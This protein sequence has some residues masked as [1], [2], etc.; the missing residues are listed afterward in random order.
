MHRLTRVDS[1][2]PDESAE[3]QQAE[4]IKLQRQFR[5][6]EDDRRAY[7]EEAEHI[8]KKQ[9]DTIA[10]LTLEHEELEKDNKLAGSQRNQT[11]DAGNTSKLHSLL[12]EEELTAKDTV[13]E[14]ERLR[15]VE[16]KIGNMRKK[17]DSLR[18]EMGGVKES[19]RRCKM[20]QK[21]N[22]VMENRLNKVCLKHN[23]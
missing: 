10:N 2:R 12:H 19:E 6:L 17:V 11:S 1:G 20:M 21:L 23:F 3:E 22:R 5:L 16:K 8:L 15:I 18:S 14:N 13:E 4:L 7:R 9:K